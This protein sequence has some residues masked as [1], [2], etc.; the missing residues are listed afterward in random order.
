MEH[1]DVIV[2]QPVVIDNVS[3]Y[4][5]FMPE[6][7]TMHLAEACYMTSYTHTHGG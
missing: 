6:K 3:I 1:Y 5:T 7:L 2:N 4:Y